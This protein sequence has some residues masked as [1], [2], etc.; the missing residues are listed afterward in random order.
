MPTE[1]DLTPYR[2]VTEVMNSRTITIF[3]HLTHLKVQKRH[4]RLDYFV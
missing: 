2:A 1:R 4:F 3:S